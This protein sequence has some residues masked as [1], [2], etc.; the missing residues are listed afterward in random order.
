[1]AAMFVYACSSSSSTNIGFDTD[2]GGTG[3]GS[4]PFT[5]GGAHDDAISLGDVGFTET[6]T[7]G[8]TILYAHTNRT[9]F[10]VDAKDPLLALTKIGDFDCTGSGAGQVNSLTD[11]AV[12]KDGKLYGIS[13]K[14][15]FLDMTLNASSVGCIGKG[16]QLPASGNFY[17]ASFAPAGTVDANDEALV[18]ASSEG[19]VFKAD[20]TSGALTPLGTLGT[21]PPDDG[22]GHTYP[23]AN[24]GKAWELSGDIVFLANGGS[25]VGFATV[26]DC[27]SPDAGSTT[28]CNK[29]DTLVEID[30][31]K[32][33]PNNAGSII[34]SVR[35]Q[36][37]KAAGCNDAAH[38]GYGSTFGIVAYQGDIIGYAREKSGTTELALTVRINNSNGTACLVADN[39]ALATGGWAGAG[40][41][42]TAPVIVPPPR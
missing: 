14:E 41:T 10:S 34:K 6:G 40:V 38:T 26:R 11:L 22:N 36:I 33:K 35:G 16:V 42:T 32:L 29:T 3:D 23:A 20:T 13:P 21:V 4:S 37:V 28:N 1:M 5:D 30:M 31:T 7:P 25:P 15:I 17:G 8:K 39:T 18:I 12:D 24:V 9:L 19:L 2:G 27:P